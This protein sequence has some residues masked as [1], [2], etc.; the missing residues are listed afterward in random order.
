MARKSKALDGSVSHGTPLSRARAALQAGNAR[1]AKRLADEAAAA[2]PESERDEARQLA[3][4]L[5][6]D[7][8]PLL[9]IGAVLILIIVAAWM[10]ILRHN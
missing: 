7:L 6:P 9:V 2:G 4:Q 10:A 3:G 1:L 5:Q 8:Q